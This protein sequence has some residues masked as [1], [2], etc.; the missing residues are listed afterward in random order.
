MAVDDL[1]FHT[2]LRPNPFS[3]IPYS[4][5]ITSNFCDKESLS[6]NLRHFSNVIFTKINDIEKLCLLMVLSYTV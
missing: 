6:Q 4:S 3:E 2:R 5:K 1:F